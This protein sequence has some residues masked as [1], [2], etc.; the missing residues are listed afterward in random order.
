MTS[1]HFTTEPQSV[2][3]ITYWMRGEP[4]EPRCRCCPDSPAHVFA[5]GAKLVDTPP[6]TRELPGS[7]WF[8]DAIS[9]V[10]EG[11]RIRVT[12]EVLNEAGGSE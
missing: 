1:R 12:V 5:Y 2:E 6:G 9:C 8:F 4:R 10:P 7:G 3:A 11:S